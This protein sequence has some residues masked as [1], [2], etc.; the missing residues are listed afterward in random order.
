HEVAFAV[1]AGKIRSNEE[2]A[3]INLSIV[4]KGLGAPLTQTGMQTSLAK[5][6]ADIKQGALD[7]LTM[8]GCMPEDIVRV[9]FV[10]GSSLL[11]P[12]QNA[13]AEACPKAELDYRDA[14]TAVVDGLALGS[15]DPMRFG[16]QPAA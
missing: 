5:E 10:G 12:V 15:A 14:F 7:T 2:D 3:Q 16:R 8:A 1:E 11:R 4:E 13:L 9:V 6:V